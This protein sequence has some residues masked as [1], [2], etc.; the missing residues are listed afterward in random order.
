MTN[1]CRKRR[2]QNSRVL[3]VLVAVSM[4]PGV[5]A[6]A[7]ESA[8]ASEPAVVDLP[9]VSVEQPSDSAPRKKKR[10]GNLTVELKTPPGTVLAEG[11]GEGP[12][13]S[14][15][16]AGGGQGAGGGPGTGDGTLIISGNPPSFEVQEYRFLRR[17]GAETVVSVTA[18][19]PGP[20]GNIREV[21]NETPGVFIPPR[22]AGSEGLI[23]IRGS[24]ISAAGP[25]T[26]RGVRVYVDNVSFGR[27]DAGLTNAFFDPLIADYIEVYRGASS[28]RFGALAT[29]GAINIVSKTGLTSPGTT[30]G[31]TGGS[32]GFLQSYVETGGQKD[33]F[34]WFAQISK[35]DY[36]GF[37]EHTE[38][39][40]LRF[41]TNVGW[42][43]TKEFETRTYVSLGDTNIDLAQPI[44]LNR[45]EELRKEA[46]LLNLRADTDRNFDYLRLSN[47]SLLRTEDTAYE[48]GFYYLQ[49]TL[50]HLPTPFAGI[51]DH[52]WRDWGASLRV[53]HTTELAGLP[54]EIVGG[55]RVNYT[56]GDFLRFQWKDGGKSKGTKF[57]DWDFESWLIEGYGEAAVEIFPKFR[58]FT[59][60]QW[61][62]T[63]RDLEDRYTGG[64]VPAVGFNPFNPLTPQP[65]RSAG[66]QEYSRDFDT[67]NPKVGVNWEHSKGH[68]LFGN[69]AKSF[70]PPTS[71]DLGDILAVE[72]TD[73]R[74]PGGV[75]LP[76]IDLP[77][78]EAQDA[79]TQEIGIRGAFD[80]F[81]YDITL[82]SMN[83]DNEI[84]T[85]CLATPC[86]QVVAFNATKTI[87]NGMEMGMRA[88]PVKGILTGEDHIYASG[89][90][91]INDF[92]FD[93]DPVFGSNRMPVIPRHQVYA[94][95]G[96]RHPSG[97]FMLGNLIYLSER[98]TTFDGSGG[99]AFVV[100]D[101]TLYGAKVGFEMPD[102]S[103]SVF[104]EGRNLADE[105]YAADFAANASVPRAPRPP[106][107]AAAS[108][109]VRPGDGRAFFAGMTLTF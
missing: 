85:R 3:P 90:W 50:D 10:A 65:G 61:A 46:G 59:G 16:S 86:T 88:I 108:P 63:T 94:E 58:L 54:T 25:R 20:R 37:Q 4:Y 32:Q 28:L 67:L 60:L 7:Q 75:L 104:V 27:T 52:T 47:K 44:P 83:I 62:Y 23:S 8:P 21:L 92:R 30:I 93:D 97:F 45:L 91:N 103:W 22:T 100:P 70:E 78:L 71:G 9:E 17:P 89:V 55:V 82:Y 98:N 96:Y 41:N 99:E 26:G 15:D 109:D 13:A 76:R 11:I 42:R 84:L 69:I 101:V 95:L 29:G 6:T 107:A 43:P 56:D 48:L 81:Q 49:T 68:F 64:A 24:D 31:V 102:E 14:G 40:N 105:I 57:L 33:A 1:P 80:R 35:F 18:Q 53:E 34:D 39:D 5:L 36:E 72:S 38:E 79:W 2:G 19:D 73:Q 87:H 74:G 77:D 51:V 12:A 66:L 106:F